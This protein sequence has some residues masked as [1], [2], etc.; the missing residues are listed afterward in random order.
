MIIPCSDRV[1]NAAEHPVGSRSNTVRIK[2]GKK[3]RT[4]GAAH[5][6]RPSSSPV[7]TVFERCRTRSEHGLI[8]KGSRSE[9]RT[10]TTG[11]TLL[12]P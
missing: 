11:L 9:N 2:V 8:T 5:V 7:L 10:V 1:R 6:F 3:G 12:R 4:C